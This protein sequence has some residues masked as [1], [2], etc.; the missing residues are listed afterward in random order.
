MILEARDITF[1]Y[2]GRRKTPVIEHFS[3]TVGS[4]ERVGLKAP[5]G[6]GKTTLCRLLAGYEKPQKVEIR[7][8]GMPLRE[9]TGACPV[10]MVWQHPETVVDPLLRLRD[11]LEEAGRIDP[12]L[13][14]KL[15]IEEGWMDR[16]PSELSGGE[17]QR[18]NIARALGCRT[19]YLLA[20]EITT[21]LDVVTQCQIWEFLI[22]ECERRNIGILAASHDEALLSRVCTRMIKWDR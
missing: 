17:L 12:E 9:Q 20:D 15:H 16:F 14:E 22:E 18:F 3:I 21:M 8:D 11:T 19:R 6:R 7:L 1:Y 4:G 5:S 2:P 10:Q 13:T